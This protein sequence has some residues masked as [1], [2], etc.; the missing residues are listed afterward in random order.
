MS[1]YD[2]EGR[3]TTGK[4]PC[5]GLPAGHAA[6]NGSDVAPLPFASAFILIISQL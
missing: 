4:S 5:L 6:N 3:P 1:C 2:E